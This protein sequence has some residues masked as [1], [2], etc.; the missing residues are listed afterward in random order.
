MESAA[1]LSIKNHLYWALVREG[2]TVQIE[3]SIYH[4]YQPDLIVEVN[5]KKVA[6]EIQKSPLPPNAMLKRMAAHTESGAYTLWLIPKESLETIL[7][8]RKWCELIQQLQNGIIFLPTETSK[9]L[10]ARIDLEFESSRKFIDYFDI[11][12]DIEDIIFEKNTI[13]GLNVA[14]WPEWWLQGYQDLYY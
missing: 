1:H 5:D 8:S 13:Y 7:Y 11:P 4:R 14:G 2:Y 6:I 3:K 10:P 12:V 9:I